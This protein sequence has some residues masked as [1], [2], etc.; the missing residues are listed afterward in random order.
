MTEVPMLAP[1]TTG[2]AVA[3]GIIPL[4]TIA[5]TIEVVVDDDCASVVAR[6]PTNRPT[7]GL[8]ALS[9]NPSTAPP[10][11]SLNALPSMPM[12]TRKA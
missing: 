9:I 4:P 5:T 1:M 6:I 10:P 7:S 12:L 11:N 2:I 3:T 8:L